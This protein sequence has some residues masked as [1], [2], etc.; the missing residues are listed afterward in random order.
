MQAWGCA[1]VGCLGR[2]GGAVHTMGCLATTTLR[3]IFCA[4]KRLM[5]FIYF[6]CDL[7]Q[8]TQLIAS[9]RTLLHPFDLQSRLGELSPAYHCK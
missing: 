3:G 8:L 7:S 4:K 2:H 5:T 9:Y 6:Y 1:G